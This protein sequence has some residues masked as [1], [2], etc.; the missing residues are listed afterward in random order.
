MS[1]DDKNIKLVLEINRALHDKDA[2]QIIRSVGR[3]MEHNELRA[4]AN[5][6]A[7][8]PSMTSN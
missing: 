4:D 6:V 8:I 7:T 2:T 3:F 5:I 1:F